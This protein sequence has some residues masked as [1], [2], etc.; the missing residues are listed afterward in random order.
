MPDQQVPVSILRG[1]SYIFCIFLFI[2]YFIQNLPLKRKLAALH[3]R[4]KKRSKLRY[5]SSC[6]EFFNDKTL[7]FA[8]IYFIII[9]ISFYSLGFVALLMI[10]F[11]V[12]FKISKKVTEIVTRPV[13][14]L[15]LIILLSV[16][17]AFVYTCYEYFV[18]AEI[19]CPDTSSCIQ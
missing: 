3:V 5:L 13:V 15:I 4:N 8:S 10:D 7:W 17:I 19:N 2:I 12:R 6:L 11:F 16:T 9:S 1:L 14:Q 18:R